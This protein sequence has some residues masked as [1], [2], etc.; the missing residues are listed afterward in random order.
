VILTN[1]TDRF[2][3]WQYSTTGVGVDEKIIKKIIVNP[4]AVFYGTY[5]AFEYLRNF[6]GRRARGSL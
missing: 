1:K 3:E 4:I 5:V 2:Y 6:T